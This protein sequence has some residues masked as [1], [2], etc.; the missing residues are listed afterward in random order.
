[1]PAPLGHNNKRVYSK[2]EMC[3]AA[4]LKLLPVIIESG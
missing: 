2:E 1:M 3:G 4:F